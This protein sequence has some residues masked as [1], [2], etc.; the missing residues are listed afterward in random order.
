MNVQTSGCP[1]GEEGSEGAGRAPDRDEA[2]SLREPQKGQE[3]SSKGMQQ[4]WETQWQQ[5]LQTLQASHPAQESPQQSEAAPWDDAKAFLASFEQVAAAC[6]WPSGEW[7]ARLLP[8]LSGEAQQAFSLLAARDK[9]DYGKVKAAILRG[10]ALR[11]EAQ[12]QHFRQFCCPELEDPRRMYSQV[13]ELCCQW[14]KPERHTKEQILELLVL[15]QF[16]ASLP[17]DIQRWVRAG[18]PD[19]CAQ[20]VALL[21]DFL[22]NRREAESGMWQEPLQEWTVDLLDAKKECLDVVQGEISKEHAEIFRDTKQNVKE[23]ASLPGLEIACSTPVLPLEDR[24]MADDE[25]SEA[26]CVQVEQGMNQREMGV[27]FHVVEKTPVQSSQQTTFWKVLQEDGE[28]VDSLGGSFGSQ[29]DLA[30]H[31]VKQEETFPPDPLE[32]Q[33]LPGQDSDDGKRTRLKGKNSRLGGTKPVGTSRRGGGRTQEDVPVTAEVQEEGCESNRE[34]GTVPLGGCKESGK[35]PQCFGA[36]CSNPSSVV[37]ERKKASSSKC[38][39]RNHPKSGLV[40]EHTGEECSE[41]PPL[42][43]KIQPKSKLDK[44]HRK[45]K[46]TEKQN[47]GCLEREIRF[48]STSLAKHQIT[49][50]GKKSCKCSDC[51]KSLSQRSSRHQMN[52]PEKKQ[53]HYAERGKNLSQRSHLLTHQNSQTGAKPNKCP[54]CGKSFSRRSALLRHQV[55]HTG[56][57]PHRCPECGKNFSRRSGLLR[58]QMIHK[59]MRPH[60]CLECGK[61]FS[62]RSHLLCHQNTHTG[63]KPHKCL[64]CGKSFSY[65]SDLLVH[66]R[67]HTGEKPHKCSK[68]GKSFSW[69][70]PLLIH[71]T[72]HTGE[73]PHKCSDCGKSF[74]QKSNLFRHQKIHTER[75]TGVL[76]VG[77]A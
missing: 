10:E 35:L 69:L 72:V 20:A 55:I 19:S 77:K 38:G 3:D 45:S 41:G 32:S 36:A 34:R 47:H 1:E 16:L 61:K 40:F 13:Q 17:A 2:E 46:V 49:H 51:G 28:N 15:E 64:Q 22:M 73:K 68:C 39:R 30:P 14:L 5:F 62:Q 42:K 21:E 33:K 67:N 50:T 37:M 52:H 74:S 4:R 58:H 76:C 6:R 48:P 66:H 53:H 29:L 43:E 11:R 18:G 7:V 12:R 75:N 25:L 23:E 70:S 60:Q 44:H 63:E 31:P 56:K 8:A 26:L 57:K 54:Q 24:D 71:L 65:R 59:G 27:P 9:G